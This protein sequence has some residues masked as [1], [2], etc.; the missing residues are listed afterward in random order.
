MPLLRASRT[1]HAMHLPLHSYNTPRPS[2]RQRTSQLKQHRSL[3]PGPLTARAQVWA[4]ERAASGRGKTMLAS[5]GSAVHLVLEGPHAGRGA[6]GDPVGAGGRRGAC[7]AVDA[8]APA[9]HERHLHGLAQ[10]LRRRRPGALRSQGP[11]PASQPRKVHCLIA[12]P[13]ASAAC[14]ALHWSSQAGLRHHAFILVDGEDTSVC[15]QGPQSSRK[16]VQAGW[17]WPRRCPHIRQGAAPGAAH[18]CN[19]KERA[20]ALR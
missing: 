9:A 10:R 4:L 2:V 1:R 6:G 16:H 8:A 14:S 20:V 13:A 7:A 3:L 5:A 18:Y 12:S 17:R 15:L 11:G 19:V